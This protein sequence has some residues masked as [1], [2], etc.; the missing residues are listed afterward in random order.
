MSGLEINKLVGALLV[1][2]LLFAVI[3]VATDQI[4]HEEPMMATV[5]PVPAGDEPEMATPA[6]PEPAMT[7]A[8]LLAAADPGN[9]RRIAKK[10]GACHDMGESAR[11]KVGPALWGI[12]GA[13][14]ASRAGY[15]YSSAFSALGGDWGYDDLDAFLAGPKAFAPGTKMA[16]SGVKD[17]AAR[18]DLVAFLRSL[19]ANPPPLPAAE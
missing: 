3:N 6:E 15:K 1:A 13:A 11:N 9:G 4:R 10:C 19:G 12:V 8:G 14:K 18:A 17:P 5:Y 7:L 16:F 2:L